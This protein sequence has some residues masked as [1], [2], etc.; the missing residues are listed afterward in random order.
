MRSAAGK[1]I[2]KIV[3]YGFIWFFV[4]ITL[5]PLILML[6][7]SVRTDEDFNQNAAAF[8]SSFRLMNFI[9]AWNIGK[10]F[11]LGVN[12]IIVTAATIGFCIILA[13]MAGFALEKMMPKWSHA[14][15]NYFVIGIIIPIQ[16]LMIPLFRVLK[17]LNLINQMPGIIMIYIA[18]NLCFGIFIYTGFYKTIP[19]ELIEA[20]EIDG[21]S[22]YR[23]F[24][25]IILPLTKPVTSTVAILTGMTVWK[26]LT[27]PLIYI[28]NPNLKTL[29]VGLF[30]FRNAFASRETV[31]TAA[32]CIQTIP[33]II[34][35]IVLQKSFVKGIA[36]GAIKG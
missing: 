20:A 7:T 13:A 18:L 19:N 8:P 34:L 3:M 28:S 24:F 27:V 36:S 16:V 26:D 23:T 25:Q 4:I 10:I 14:L 33:I 12:T 1:I 21:S 29:S 30:Y 9:E 11:T 2:A 6:F 5:Y 17:Q 32:M 31:M 15:Y 22:I 35:F